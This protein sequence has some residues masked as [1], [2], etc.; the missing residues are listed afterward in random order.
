M[1]GVPDGDHYIVTKSGL[2]ELADYL[3]AVAAWMADAKVCI[4]GAR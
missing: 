4:G 3:D 2:D 1:G